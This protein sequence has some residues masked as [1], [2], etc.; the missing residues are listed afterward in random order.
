MASNFPTP[1]LVKGGCLCGALRYQVN[2]PADHDFIASSSTCQ[3]TQCRKQTASLFLLSHNA[4]D[5]AFQLTGDLSALKHFNA[6]PS[7][8]RGFCS[9]CGSFLYWRPKN[10][11]NPYYCFTVGTVDP[12]Y[13]FGEGADGV[14]TGGQDEPVPKGG[15]GVALASGQGH[16]YYCA[17]EIPGVTDNIPLL[18]L[19]GKGGTRFQGDD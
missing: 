3:C 19:G 13:L 4:P 8:E 1:K 6:S 10:R 12:L 16:H 18:G 11:P 2:F 7:A 15:Y 9:Q 5:A 17:N 14:E